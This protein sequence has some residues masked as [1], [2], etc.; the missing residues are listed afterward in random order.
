MTYPV[1]SVS[2]QRPRVV[3]GWC[4]GNT[5]TPGLICFHINV[6]AMKENVIIYLLSAAKFPDTYSSHVVRP[7]HGASFCNTTLKV[8][9]S[10]LMC[11]VVNT[12]LAPAVLKRGNKYVLLN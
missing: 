9:C 3:V 5:E 10:V 8:T 1:N 12:S 4:E 2:S 7:T 6:I 11:A